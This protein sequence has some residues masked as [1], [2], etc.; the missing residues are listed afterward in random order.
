MAGS[1]ICGRALE[2]MQRIDVWV[3]GSVPS[4]THRA[5]PDAH[6]AG[7]TAAEKQLFSPPKASHQA[8]C[9]AQYYAAICKGS[10]S[11]VFDVSAFCFRS[12]FA[13]VD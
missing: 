7:C 13:C 10:Q 8:S 1:P 12:S 3:N 2:K 4:A 11:F 5:A 9:I 6:R